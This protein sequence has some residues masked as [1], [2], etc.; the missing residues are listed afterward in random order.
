MQ[1]AGYSYTQL[2]KT[3]LSQAVRGACTV[4]GEGW[5]VKIPA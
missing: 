3:D 5:E 4:F 1:S 2:R